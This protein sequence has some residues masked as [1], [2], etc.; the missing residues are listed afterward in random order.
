MALAQKTEKKHTPYKD[1]FVSF[2]IASL[3]AMSAVTFSNPIEVVKTRLQLQG[4]LVRAGTLSVA[5]RPYHN[6]FQA[7]NLIFKN[8]GFRGI[9]RGLGVAYIY[10]V[11]LNGSR[12]GLYGP[13]HN[14][15]IETLG[16]QSAQ[17]K[18]AAGVFAGG[19][20]GVV[21]A[22]LGSP[23]YLIKTRR[24]SFSPVFKNIGHQHEIRGSSFAAL[25][26]IYR[27]E[28]VKGLYRGVSAA[29]LRAA[30]GSSV[31]VPSYMF[32]KELLMNR[33]N[34]PDTLPTHLATS[35]CSGFLVAVVMNPPDVISTR[36]YNQGVDPKTG[37]GLLYKST[38][39]CLR[40]IIHTEGFR[41]LYKG[42]LAHF[43]R[44]G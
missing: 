43:L 1:L 14:T 6:S 29:V 16:L 39:D 21:G 30:M 26:Q 34:M 18:V 36:M 5:S 2:S 41:G 23:L 44:I 40:K 19:V 15:V 8:E 32:G 4:E 17:S 25:A 22:I 10:Q 24:Q 31:Q 9:Q 13:V 7:M 20:A 37:K 33:F 42:F 28:G 27:Q 12:L 3:A 38:F 11:C 35:M